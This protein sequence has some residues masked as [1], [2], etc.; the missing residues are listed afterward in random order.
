VKSEDA[1][2]LGLVHVGLLILAD[3]LLQEVSLLGERDHLYLLE[4]V[5]DVVKLEYSHSKK[6][7]G[8]PRT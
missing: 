7:D 6:G 1:V 5:L 3:A 8:Q 4:G 2:F